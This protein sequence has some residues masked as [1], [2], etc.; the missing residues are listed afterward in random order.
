[1]HLL[2][3]TAARLGWPFPEHGR[4]RP[5]R[6][7]RTF[8][9]GLNSL[10]D[11]AVPTVGALGL[12][13]GNFLTVVGD[14]TDNTIVVRQTNGQLTID[15]GQFVTSSGTV[16]SI[17][18]SSVGNILVLAGAGDDTVQIDS[19]VK[20]NTIIE[21]GDGNDTLA[22]GG[23]TTQLFGGSGNDSLYGGN[24]S[25]RLYGGAGD[26]LLVGGGGLDVAYS[27]AGSD[28]LG[29]S[30]E[31]S[32]D[33]SSSDTA[34]TSEPAAPALPTATAAA[35][36]T[37]G[38]FRQPTTLSATLIGDV[39]AIQGTSSADSIKLTLTNGSYA[40]ADGTPITTDS[41]QVSSVSASSVREVVVLGYNGDDTIDLSASTAATRI[42]GGNGADT[43]IGGSA[44]D[45]IYGS[46]GND[47]IQANGG[48]DLVYG[49]S[50][51]DTID[52]GA[53]DDVAYGGAGTDTIN[54]GAGSDRVVDAALDILGA[55]VEYTGPA[56]TAATQPIRLVG[57]RRGRR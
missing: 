35:T 54:G 57:R 2:R 51:N 44:S 7:R 14:D 16:S 55:D 32:P 1:M 24:A 11:R 8:S 12:L 10:E 38:S 31:S 6:P 41:G 56:S 30:I 23:G 50:G 4:K 52:L 46:A 9:P 26:D 21:G 29:K 48:N 15:G 49:G 36:P 45:L 18:A 3:W 27:G 22:A 33:I 39:L 40:L 42:I 47:I 28:S 17:A 20:I 25:D 34:L 13:D 43:L 53:G 5:S 37:L 19:S